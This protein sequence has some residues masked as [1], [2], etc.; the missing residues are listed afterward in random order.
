MSGSTECLLVLFNNS[1]T[2]YLLHRVQSGKIYYRRTNLNTLKF[3]KNFSILKVLLQKTLSLNLIN[4]AHNY[5]LSIFV[6]C[7]PVTIHTRKIC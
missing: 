2:K 5:L 7:L 6:P 1:A 4:F 3:T